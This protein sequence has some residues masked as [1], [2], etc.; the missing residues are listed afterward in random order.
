[1][2]R[3]GESQKLIDLPVLT[4]RTMQEIYLPDVAPQKVLVESGSL[5]LDTADD[6]Y[7]S[8]YYKHMAQL[9]QNREYAENLAP[10]MISAKTSDGQTPQIYVLVKH[11]DEYHVLLY[12]SKTKTVRSPEPEIILNLLECTEDTD[13]ALVDPN[14][15]E[16]LSD[17]C[18][19][20]WCI[21]NSVDE[22]EVIRECALYLKPEK[23]GNKDWL[24]PQP[25]AV[26]D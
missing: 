13:T 20:A 5:K 2:E 12:E 7:V 8:P 25:T 26:A 21:Q 10:D 1:M 3:H 23:E 16:E 19:R 18:I 6:D 17:A 9:Q 14:Q 22:Q 4:A 24:N 11:D 15:V